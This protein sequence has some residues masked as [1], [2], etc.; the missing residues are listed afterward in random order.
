MTNNRSG[1]CL[2]KLSKLEVALFGTEERFIGPNIKHRESDQKS[3][4]GIQPDNFALRQP[5]LPKPLTNKQK[6]AIKRCTK[7]IAE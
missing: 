2:I 5:A 1:V 4:L 7:K 3:Y 6:R